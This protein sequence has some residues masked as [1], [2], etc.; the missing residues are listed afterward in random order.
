[1]DD[2]AIPA[3]S[4][5]ES[6][7][8]FLST[9]S[10]DERK[11]VLSRAFSKSPGALVPDAPA[12]TTSLV[13]PGTFVPLLHVER[14]YRAKL[15]PTPDVATEGAKYDAG[16][17]RLDLI[18]PELL[19]GVAAILGFGADKYAPRNWEHGMD[20]GRVYAAALRHLLAWWGGEDNDR[21]TGM[22]HLWHAGCCISFLIAYE[23]RGMTKFD[24]RPTLH[25]KGD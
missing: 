6:L 5:I 21:E 15:D 23:A 14:S 10:L 8:T 3:V 12:E 22:P 4:D 18:P 24:D 11:D 2:R 17:A 1:M 25:K 16:K 9:L 7:L 20:F 13:K 19:T